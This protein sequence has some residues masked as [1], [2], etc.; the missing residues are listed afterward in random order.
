VR[1]KNVTIT[2]H[3]FPAGLNFAVL[4]GPYG[5]QGINGIKVGTLKSG[6]GGTITATYPI[7]AS[8]KGSYR[9]AIRAQNYY[10]GYYAYNWFYNYTTK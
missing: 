1:N 6:K 2:T 10:S 8:L 9:I 7:P 4:M 5:T 3:N